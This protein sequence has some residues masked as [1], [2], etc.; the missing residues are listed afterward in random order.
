MPISLWRVWHSWGLDRDSPCYYHMLG[1]VPRW[2]RWRWDK[3]PLCMG[4]LLK[5]DVAAFCF[6]FISCGLWSLLLAT[7]Q[8]GEAV[9]EAISDDF[10]HMTWVP[11]EI[12]AR[13]EI[14]NMVLLE[15]RRQKLLL[16][17]IFCAN[18]KQCLKTKAS[19]YWCFLSYKSFVYFSS[20]WMNTWARFKNL[21]KF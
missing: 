8:W 15:G 5:C 9:S 3:K 6:G 7:L 16:I 21:N 18:P 10:L 17:F 20:K 12:P 11:E 2:L 4:L 1:M 14:C 13:N 19:G